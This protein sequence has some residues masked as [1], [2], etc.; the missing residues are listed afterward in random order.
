MQKKFDIHRKNVRFRRSIYIMFICRTYNKLS[1][2]WI[3]WSYFPPVRH[4]SLVFIKYGLQ[5]CHQTCPYSG[6]KLPFKPFAYWPTVAI[7]T[8]KY[9]YIIQLQRYLRINNLKIYFT[10]LWQIPYHLYDFFSVL[11]LNNEF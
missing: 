7:T 9:Y 3:W 2:V 8:F 6:D 10:T 1:N 4:T 11:H 5:I